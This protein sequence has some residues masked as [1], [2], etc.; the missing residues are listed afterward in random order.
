LS[1][2]DNAAI[3]TTSIE[4]PRTTLFRVN[5]IV[6]S[7]GEWSN[8]LATP[9]VRVEHFVSKTDTVVSARRSIRAVEDRAGEPRVP[10]AV[11]E[12]DREQLRGDGHNSALDAVLLFKY[13][14]A[15]VAL[16]GGLGTLDELSEALT[17]V[18]TGKVENFPIVLIGT[19]Y[20]RPFRDML[21]R[22]A[23]EGTIGHDDL[24]LMLVTDD[25]EEAMDH[26]RRYAIERFGLRPVVKPSPFLGEPTALAR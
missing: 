18:Q 4:K 25:L 17:L 13:S 26:I 7:D 12:T 1:Y 9:F 19:E 8:N 21:D 20:W 2:I 6:A 16:P 22:M 11:L 15:F 14:Y 5:S 24:H 23:V 10:K 3:S